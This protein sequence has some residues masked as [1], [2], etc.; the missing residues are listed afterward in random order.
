MSSVLWYVS[1]DGHPS[2]TAECH[3]SEVILD[4]SRKFKEGRKKRQW[5]VWIEHS[6]IVYSNQKRFLRKNECLYE[7]TRDGRIRGGARFL[8]L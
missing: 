1:G 8:E 7:S 4:W 2:L 5:M 6:A 3:G